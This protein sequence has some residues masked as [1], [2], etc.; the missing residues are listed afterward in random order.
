MHLFGLV[1]L[2]L[3]CG[4]LLI[5]VYLS[6][7]WL[8]GEG[9]GSRPLLLLGILMTVTGVQFASLGLLGEFLTYQGQK[10]GYRDTLP[11]RERIGF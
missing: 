3:G 6:V 7:L 8:R 4:G 9:I 5:N 1:G 10:R 11:V 2:V